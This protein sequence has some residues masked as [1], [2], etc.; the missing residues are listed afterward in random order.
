MFTDDQLRGALLEEVILRLLGAS[1]YVTVNSAGTDPT[2]GNNAAGLTVKG[3]GGEHQI[4]AIADAAVN[5]PFVNPQRL[6]VE[7]K[8]LGSSSKLRLSVVRNALGVLRD[9]S[10]YWVGNPTANLSSKRYHYQYAIFS[11]V[12]FTTPA[13]RYAFA[14]DIY[15][16]PLGR[17]SFF[18]PLIAAINATRAEQFSHTE[19]RLKDIRSTVSGRLQGSLHTERNVTD[20]PFE[21]SGISAVIEACANLGFSLVAVFG[22]RFPVF[23]SPSETLG[24]LSQRDSPRITVRIYWNDESWFVQTCGG[25][26]LFSFDLPEELFE[27]YAEQG[28]LSPEKALDLKVDFM[29]A[30][31]AIHTQNGRAR[32]LN[33]KLDQNWITAL[34]EQN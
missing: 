23:L 5:P 17:S 1:G 8:C 14:Q 9:V 7:A 3:R 25:E 2:L 19:L 30:F 20:G 34:R 12:G 31:Q 16:F 15:L 27:L 21:E 26:N 33:F 18:A 32:I 22:G 4:D 29:S 28:E 13:Q 24:E 10:E 11:T 6:L